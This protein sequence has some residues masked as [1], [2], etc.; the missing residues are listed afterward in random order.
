MLPDGNP[1][2]HKG[3]N[4]TINGNCI[5][6]CEVF[7]SYYLHLYKR[8]STKTIIIMCDGTVTCV[9]VWVLSRSVL[10]DSA[11]PRAVARKAPLSLGILQARRPE[12][13][14]MPSP[15]GFSQARDLTKSP[16]LE[17]DSSPSEPPGKP[18][19]SSVAN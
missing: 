1:D 4:S 2:L 10:S 8:Q 15:R 9:A 13:V 3:I 7:P 5:Y 11:T 6:K 19:C 17:A 12:W 16:G 14:A 18:M